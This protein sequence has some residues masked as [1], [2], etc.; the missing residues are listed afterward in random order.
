MRRFESF[1]GR[2][3][4]AKRKTTT[5]VTLKKG[6][7]TLTAKRE[8]TTEYDRKSK[9]WKQSQHDTLIKTEVKPYSPKLSR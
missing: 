1:Q 2:I 7:K 6:N 8:T 4:V 3:M 9:T 5:T